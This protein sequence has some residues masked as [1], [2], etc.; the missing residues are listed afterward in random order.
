M[1]EDLDD[2]FAGIGEKDRIRKPTRLTWAQI[3]IMAI[4]VLIVSV[5]AV[6]GL[7]LAAV[8]HR[9]QRAG[10]VIAVGLGL[11]C[12]VYSTRWRYRKRD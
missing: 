3:G 2:P 6:I 4:A 1:S 8:Y 10:A 7:V 9:P 5:S 11:G 12:T